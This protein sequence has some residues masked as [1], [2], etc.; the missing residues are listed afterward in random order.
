MFYR[1]IYA[2]HISL[3][4]V[5][6]CTLENKSVFVRKQYS[7]L[8]SDSQRNQFYGL[9]RCT[10]YIHMFY[11]QTQPS[12][13]RQQCPRLHLNNASH[14]VTF[15]C[16]HSCRSSLLAGT[17]PE[18]VGDQIHSPGAHKILEIRLYFKTYRYIYNSVF[19]ISKGN[20]KL[21]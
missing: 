7:C 18:I 12:N 20:A 11:Q 21:S 13:C 8:S 9:I 10:V 14:I 5:P 6:T 19:K 4:N 3:M 2:A 15:S 16:H 1:T 17:V